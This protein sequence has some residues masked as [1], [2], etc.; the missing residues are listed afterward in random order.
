MTRSRNG[1]VG[2]LS[3]TRNPYIINTSREPRTSLRT[4]SQGNPI[5]QI[6]PSQK[7]STP[8]YHLRKR[9][10]PTSNCHPERLPPGCYHY[11][12]PR[13]NRVNRKIYC[14]QAVCQLGKMMHINRT[15]RNHEQIT[16]RN[17]TRRTDNPGVIFCSISAKKSVWRNM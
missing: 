2:H 3:V 4:H 10:H 7:N 16:G 8:F 13:Y 15:H 17:P 12:H 11:Q 9:N 5:Y 14:D 6:S 1:W